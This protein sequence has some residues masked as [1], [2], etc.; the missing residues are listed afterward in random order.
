M[1]ALLVAS[2]TVLAWQPA[3]AVPVIDPKGQPAS[4]GG[5]NAPVKTPPGKG[6]PTPANPT[7]PLAVHSGPLPDIASD[8]PEMVTLSAFSE[9]VNMATLVELVATTLE[10]NITIV[11][12]VPGMVRFNAPVPIRK[13]DLMS[14]LRSLLE[15]QAWTITRDQFGLYTVSAINQVVPNVGGALSSTRVFRT[16]NMRPTSLKAAIEGQVGPPGPGPGGAARQYAYIDD[17][18]IIVATDTPGRLD[19]IGQVVN[20]IIAEH[21]QAGFERLP[22]EH[23]SASVARERALQLI[24]MAQPAAATAA[25]GGGRAPGG[26]GGEQPT[27]R[28]LSTLYSLSER[29]SVDQQGNALIFRG[30][31]D[32][33][34]QVKRVVAVIDVPNEL[35]PR[36]YRAGRS[37]SQ[38]ADIARGRGL[39]EVITI[40][41][42]SA[43]TSGS[44][45]GVPQGRDP[46]LL[47]Q[48]Q[49]AGTTPTIVGGPLMVV[50]EGRGQIIYYGTA[51][52]QEQ[53]KALLDQLDT[54]AEAIVTRVYKLKNA[55]AVD[56]ADIING[57]ITGTG[58]VA[59][60]PLL[61]GDTGGSGS[62][63]RRSTPSRSSSSVSRANT[64][65]VV[66]AP[67][68]GGDDVSIDGGSAF[69]YPD[70]KNNQLLVKAQAGQQPEFARLIEKLDLRRPQ[71]YI[72]AKIVA[73]TT[74]DKLRTAFE[75]QLI[76]A[77]GTGG[78]F[79]QSFG[80][81]TYAATGSILTP[82]TV[83]PFTGFT[84]AV[85]RNDMV[86]I[87]MTALANETDSRIISNPQLLVDDNEE[88]EVVSLDEQPT[89]TISRGTTGGSGDIVTQGESATAGTTLH[90]KPQISGGGHLRLE[91]NIELSSFTGQGEVVGGTRLSPPKQTNTITSSS[92]T[93]PSDYTIV[94]G[95][96]VVDSKSKTVAKIPLLGDIPLV[97]LLFQDRST[98]N[99]KTVLYVFLTPKI[100]R[101]PTF[102]DLKL[103]TRGPQARVDLD[104]D[105]PELRPSITEI[106]A[107]GQPAP[108][109]PPPQP[110]DGASTSAVP[111]RNPSDW[112]NPD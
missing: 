57:L 48:G 58:P 65:R 106:V 74:D 19:A 50:D 78:V 40:A 25:P 52:Q 44:S 28:N 87:V 49:A 99:R 97:G 14:L 27:A 39:G 75:T 95:G 62:S 5:A 104:P 94:V 102:N 2:G 66:G 109:P 63:G 10:I 77:A 13:Q 71:V 6:Q 80:L 64:P 85:I 70:E 33:I 72:E 12:D 17:L 8:D 29:L 23:I 73:V 76:N 101:D 42:L 61:P 38:V 22:L 20:A 54:E 3:K 82:P 24:G 51:S 30:T 84:G 96:L 4:L 26:G 67:A 111:T 16:P 79:T 98:G 92:I 46:N 105:V 93:I 55:Q 100:L 112:P 35:I 59:A 69:V 32:E 11:G 36:T 56:L 89:T 31:S 81:A 37:A 91:Y 68:S 15:Q 110:S 107:P 45:F 18:G 108:A 103:L 86:P 21:L 34:E 88:A 83:N 7:P 43:M 60:A 53:L 9:P 47:R 41:D 90:V 1:G